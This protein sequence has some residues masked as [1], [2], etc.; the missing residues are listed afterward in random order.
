MLVMCKLSETQMNQVVK[1]QEMQL[2]QLADENKQL[3]ETIDQ[4]KSVIAAK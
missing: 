2:Q 4:Q 3:H 1:P